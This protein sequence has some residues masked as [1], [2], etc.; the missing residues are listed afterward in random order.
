MA[1]RAALYVCVNSDK[2]TAKNQVA[3]LRLARAGARLRTFR[4]TVVF[5]ADSGHADR[6]FRSMPIT[7][8]GQGDHPGRDAAG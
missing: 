8:S 7:R 6:P 3:E 5:S 4:V 1:P 2:Q